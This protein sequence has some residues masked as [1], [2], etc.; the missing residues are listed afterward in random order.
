MRV[1]TIICFA[2]CLNIFAQD[3]SNTN[4]FYGAGKSN[5]TLTLKS[6][7]LTFT[8]KAYRNQVSKL[9]L[10]EANK[11]ATELAL[12]EQIPMTSSNVIDQHITPPRM[13]KIGVGSITTSN[14]VYYFSVGDKFSS[15]VRTDSN[16]S[17]KDGIKAKYLW[18]IDRMDTNAAYQMATQWLE[19]VSIDVKA[20]NRDCDAIVRAWTPEGA[21]GKVFVPQYNVYWVAKGM[22]KAGSVAGVELL[23]PT[24][25]LQQLYVKKSQY[26]LRAPLQVTNFIFLLKTNNVTE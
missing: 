7:P 14:Y 12:N 23:M 1:F 25:S 5:Q 4:A 6:L 21:N 22:N 19:A 3:N 15:V 16:Q 8:T 2:F 11:V 18:P 13:A 9:M 10:I 20:L 17:K 24:K 26:I